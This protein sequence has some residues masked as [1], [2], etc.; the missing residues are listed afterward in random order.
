MVEAGRFG[1]ATDAHTKAL[2]VFRET[3]VRHHDD[4]ALLA[5]TVTHNERQA[6]PGPKGI[7]LRPADVLLPRSASAPISGDPGL[8][9]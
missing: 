9:Q 8:G 1:G 2:V 4:I 5:Q 7:C 6:V 3:G